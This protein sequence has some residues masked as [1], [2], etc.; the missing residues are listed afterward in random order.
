[1][2]R[3]RNQI[4]GYKPRPRFECTCCLMCSHFNGVKKG[5][6]LA[7]PQGI[8]DRYAV[9]NMYGALETHTNIEPDQVG[10]YTFSVRHAHI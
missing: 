4:D 2:P 9:R 8:P 5:T 3:Y 7:Y 1:M 10:N 6:C